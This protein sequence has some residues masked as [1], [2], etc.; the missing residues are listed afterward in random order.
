MRS[1][2]HVTFTEECAMCTWKH[3]LVNKCLQTW[4]NMDLSVGTCNKKVRPSSGNRLPLWLGKIFWA[5]ESVKKVMQ[6][7]FWDM[8]RTIT[9]DFFEKGATINSASYFQ[10]FRNISPYLLNDPCRFCVLNENNTKTNS[11]KLKISFL[12]KIYLNM[13]QLLILLSFKWKAHFF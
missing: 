10:L 13:N 6:T 5:Q 3:A 7:I 9:I 2:K 11:E 1:A 4:V 8:K 12:I